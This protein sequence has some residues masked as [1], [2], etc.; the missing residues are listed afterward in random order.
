MA[1][2]N[3]LMAGVVAGVGSIFT[4]WF[5]TGFLFHPFQRHT[6]A[7]WRTEGPRQYALASATNVVA[8]LVIA[9]FFAMTGGV[10]SLAGGNWLA[11]GLLFGALCWAALGAPVL[12]S[13][14]LFVNLHRGVVMGLLLD[15]L[16]V[17]LLAATA[18]AWVLHR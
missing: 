8:S 3:A 15:W 12:L 11:N 14:A 17:S 13:V 10:A 6:P 1:L 7:T 9:L 2:G 5:F 4:S 18:T 16:V